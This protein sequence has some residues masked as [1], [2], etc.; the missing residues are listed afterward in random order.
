MGEVTSPLGGWHDRAS[1]DFGLSGA[2][3]TPAS[4]WVDVRLSGP[5]VAV[6]QRAGPVWVS[7]WGRRGVDPGAVGGSWRRA[8][9]RWAPA[10]A[11]T[12]SRMPASW[13]ARA[14]GAARAA[15]GAPRWAGS[16][17]IGVRTR[18]LSC[19]AARAARTRRAGPAA[20]GQPGGG[21]E[22]ARRQVADGLG[23][24][25]TAAVMAA[26]GTVSESPPMP[27]KRSP[28]R[29]VSRMYGGPP[30]GREPAN[31]RP[32]GLVAPRQG[33][34]E[35]DDAEQRDGRPGQCSLLWLRTAATV[36]GPRNSTATAVPR[37]DA[38]R[39]QPGTPW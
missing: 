18:W 11:R 3:S 19:G 8:P 39:S 1:T 4:R 34:V 13:A 29:W 26:T 37:S 36:R 9:P 30:E 10:P 32:A 35:Q 24:P 23:T 17:A 20:D 33:W 2:R 16:R 15:R 22:H 38:A 12:T 14:S 28:M 6:S 31:A 5:G 21:C 7:R 25:T 27:V